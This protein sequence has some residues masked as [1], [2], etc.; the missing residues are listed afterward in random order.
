MVFGREGGGHATDLGVGSHLY[1]LLL[2]VHG[3]W[4]CEN[5]CYFSSPILGCEW[6]YCGMVIGSSI[7]SRILALFDPFTQSATYFDTLSTFFQNQNNR[8]SCCFCNK[9]TVVIK[10]SRRRHSINVGRLAAAQRFLLLFVMRLILGFGFLRTGCCRLR[11]FFLF[12]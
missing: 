6:C 10:R 11:G 1:G 2:K 9:M 8:L 4:L 12:S 5:F 3:Q 7:E